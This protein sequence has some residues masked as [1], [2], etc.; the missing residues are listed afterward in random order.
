MDIGPLLLLG[1]KSVNLAAL[2]K[3][4]W[5]VLNC[6]KNGEFNL[7]EK[8]ICFITPFLLLLLNLDILQPGKQFRRLEIYFVMV[9]NRW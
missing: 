2:A 9:M 6:L 1:R 8:F 3:L 5:N 4:G 7:Y